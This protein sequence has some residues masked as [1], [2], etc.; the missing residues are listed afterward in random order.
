[1]KLTLP[2]AEIY[3]LD[4]RPVTHMTIGAHPDDI[5]FM[6]LHGILECFQQA[7][8]G[9]VGV[10]VTNGS[11]SAR[12]GAYRN[13]TDEEMRT[14][15]RQEQK[16]AAIIGEYR[17]VCFLD[18]P[19][20]DIKSPANLGP[21]NDIASIIAELKPT[22]LYT[23]NPAD[24]H[25]THIA[26]AM[27]TILAI[28]SLPAESRPSK[29]YGCEGWRNLDWMQDDEKILLNLDGHENLAA[30]LAGVFDSQIA[31]GKRY[32]LATIG[33]WMANATYVQSHHTDQTERMSYAM[34]LTPLIQDD[35]LDITNYTLGF[36][37]RFEENVHSS[38][39]S[40][41]S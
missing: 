9:F 37:K 33:R 39:K 25:T 5:E 2:S 31:G 28:R 24:K 10:V 14:I 6:A 21:R 32:D 30:A 16:K 4:N 27:H 40:F 26:T 29:V 18:Y 7:D 22:I 3:E 34:D 8:K 35:T 13:Y 17:S 1:M 38:L 20:A 11:G 12:D 23:H 19:S 36:I 15:R 41:Q